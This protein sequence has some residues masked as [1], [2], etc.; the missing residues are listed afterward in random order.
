MKVFKEN[1]ELTITLN[2]KEAFILSNYLGAT[3]FETT[4]EILVDE[5][6]TDK[7]AKTTDKLLLNIFFELD[8][9]LKETEETIE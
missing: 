6:G 4:K 2:E 8:D 5:Y 1:K 9:L 3:S 7:L